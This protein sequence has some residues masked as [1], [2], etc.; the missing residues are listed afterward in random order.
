MDNKKFQIKTSGKIEYNSDIRWTMEGPGTFWITEPKITSAKCN[1]GFEFTDQN[2]TTMGFLLRA[3]ILTFLKTNTQLQIWFDDV[4]EVTWVYEDQD[5]A[6]ECKMR[7]DMTGLK[8]KSSNRTDLVS[9][10]YRY[11]IGLI[12]NI[13]TLLQCYG[14]ENM[15]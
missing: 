10:H 3:G 14:I 11:Q 1:G 6:N 13:L 12:F 7:K 15:H 5:E 8:F 4:L 2:K 9:T